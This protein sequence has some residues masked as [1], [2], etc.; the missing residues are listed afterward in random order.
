MS[1]AQAI[2]PG[3]EKLLPGPEKLLPGPGKPLFLP[4]PPI[5][6][7]GDANLTS[8]DPTMLSPPSLRAYAD[9]MQADY[10]RYRIAKDSAETFYN[11]LAVFH[12]SLNPFRYYLNPLNPLMKSLVQPAT[13]TMGIDLSMKPLGMSLPPPPP[14]LPFNNLEDRKRGLEEVQGECNVPE[15]KL[16]TA[17][18]RK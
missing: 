14:L 13:A 2:L 10:L 9:R 16:K 1:P 4:R 5:L 18:K 6:T 7:P 15:K 3:P 12:S 8:R 11:R 17:G